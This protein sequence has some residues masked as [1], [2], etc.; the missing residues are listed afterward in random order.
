MS[1][2]HIGGD[3]SDPFYRYKRDIIS[4]SIDKKNHKTRMLNLEKFSIS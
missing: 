4:I 3:E 1:K 2:K